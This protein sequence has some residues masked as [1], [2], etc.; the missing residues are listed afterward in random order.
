MPGVWFRHR[1]LGFGQRVYLLNCFVGKV[2]C[3][4]NS[5]LVGGGRPTR[6]PAQEPRQAF[7]V[8]IFAAAYSAVPGQI[9]VG[10]TLAPLGTA[11]T[12]LTVASPRYESSFSSFNVATIQPT[13]PAKPGIFRSG[14]LEEWRRECPMGFHRIVRR[15]H[16]R[17]VRYFIR[18]E[19]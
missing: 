1:G 12:P 2:E 10:L 3:W 5:W 9:Q 15:Q 17:L 18:A 6:Q 8:V 14:F 16:D 11:L 7:G 13:V 4:Q 19:Q